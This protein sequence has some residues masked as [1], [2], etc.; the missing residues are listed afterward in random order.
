[1]WGGVVVVKPL[2]PCLAWPPPDDS[3]YVAYKNVTPH[4]AELQLHSA[5]HRRQ[6]IAS[7]SLFY[8][9]EAAARDITQSPSGCEASKVTP[10][11]VC[12][13]PVLRFADQVI[14]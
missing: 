4:Y 1:M 10:L 6:E 3:N 12:H 7:N 9:G 13:Q 14:Q 5:R 11:K 2:P 8:R